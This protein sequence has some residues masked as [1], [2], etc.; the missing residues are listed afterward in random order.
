VA[1]PRIEPATLALLGDIRGKRVLDLACGTGVLARRLVR[2][3]ARV[4]GADG[5]EEFIER[6][7]RRPG[8]AGV[9]F[10]VVDALD[11]DAVSSLGV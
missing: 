6:A 3:G 1:S 11:E 4:T 9:E 10:A 7:G 5:S 2:S 8:S